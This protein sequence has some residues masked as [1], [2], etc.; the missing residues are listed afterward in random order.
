VVGP[1]PNFP[2]EAFLIPIEDG[3]R[4][5]SLCGRFGDYPPT[6]EAGFL[7]F[8][9][10]LHTPKIYQI[11]RRAQRVSEITH[12]RY[13]TAVRRHYER[14]PAF[15]EGF[16]VVGDA[17]CSFNPIYGQGMSSAALQAEALQHALNERMERPAPL[18]GLAH[19]FFAKAAEVV[20][21]PWLLATISDFA[22]PR[23]K[24]ERPPGLEESGR[25]LAAVEA[26]SADDAE[27]EALV[28]EVFSLAKPLP[29]LWEEPLRSRV[30][31]KMR[32]TPKT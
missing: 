6:D 27:L 11:V 18:E 3:V 29:K 7:A 28:W 23:T 13:P 17:L 21:T 5:L 14:M 19:S 26:L 16:L 31:A 12:H 25:Y 9:K 10:S 1:A 30:L 4:L 32:T 24:G 8:A 20:D 2:N 22:H 15:P